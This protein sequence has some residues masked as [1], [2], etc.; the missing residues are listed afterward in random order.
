VIFVNPR[1]TA[2]DIKNDDKSYMIQTR[3]H[4]LLSVLRS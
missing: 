2:A 4:T 1:G 3:F